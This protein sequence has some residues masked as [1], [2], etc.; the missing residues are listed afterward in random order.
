MLFE[1]KLSV[2]HLSIKIQ[3]YSLMEIKEL[4]QM[5]LKYYISLIVNLN[6]HHDKNPHN[7]ESNT[8]KLKQNCFNNLTLH[9]S[10]HFNTT[11]FI[12]LIVKFLL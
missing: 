3:S 7:K 1:L 9:K 2:E 8:L 4:K 12:R 5:N 11:E 6:F 10:T